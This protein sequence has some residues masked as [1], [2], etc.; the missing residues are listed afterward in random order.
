MAGAN[1]FLMMEEEFAAAPP[2]TSNPFLMDSSGFPEAGDMPMTDNPFFG[3]SNEAPPVTNGTNPFAF[4]FGGPPVVTSA[5][6][7]NVDTF[8]SVSNEPSNIFGIN[9]V[10]APQQPV[11]NDLMS[12]ETNDMLGNGQCLI[13]DPVP[14]V[15]KPDVLHLDQVNTVKKAEDAAHAYSSDEEMAKM[16]PRRPPP[17]ARP[18]APPCKETQDLLMSVMGAMDATSS[19]LL[20]RIPPTRTPSPVSMRDLHSPSPTPDNVFADLL[21]VQDNSAKAN[22]QTTNITADVNLLD[23]SEPEQISQPVVEPGQTQP[24]QAQHIQAQPI[25]AQQVQAQPIQAQPIPAQPIQMQPVQAQSMQAQPIQ[26]QPIQVQPVLPE[27]VNHQPATLNQT[28]NNQDPFTSLMS[29]E[30]TECDINQ[31]HNIQQSKQVPPSRPVPPRPIPPRP[32]PPQK[33][34]PPARSKPTTPETTMPSRPMVPPQPTNHSPVAPQPVVPP[35]PISPPKQNNFMMEDDNFMLGEKEKSTEKHPATTADIMNLYSAPKQAEK[36]EPMDLLCDNGQSQ[37]QETNI[38]REHSQQDLH[39]DTSD[40]QSKG[41][42]SSATFNPFTS[43]ETVVPAML[44][45]SPVKSADIP[46]EPVAGFSNIFGQAQP[47]PEHVVEQSYDA[48]G[49]QGNDEFDAF[50]AKFDSVASGNGKGVSADPFAGGSAWGDVH[51]SAGDFSNGFDADEPFDAFLSMQ[52]PPA[53]PQGT[54]AMLS[55]RE[56][57]ESDEDKDFSVVIR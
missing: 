44:D 50:A 23:V 30:N 6:T 2:P 4:D 11:V 17:P 27:P 16:L 10:Q 14:V 56:S 15:Q 42:A 47:V 43:E 9:E 18:G 20:D 22:N 41:S 53:V 33:P 52:A 46:P 32:S 5:P 51:D 29:S 13:G 1:P 34:P 12:A 45:T 57:Q 49:S 39:M 3:F 25:Q 7:T 36:A 38:S 8:F 37:P 54:P 35:K 48:F 21:D 28:T 24:I 31:N 55:K 26:A 40:T 19:H